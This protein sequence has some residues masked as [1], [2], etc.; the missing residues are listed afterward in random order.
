MKI[1]VPDLPYAKEALQPHISAQTVDIHYEKHH[2]GYL[3]KLKK[4]LEG[5]PALADN[6]LE[7]LIQR[8]PEATFNNAAQVWNHT[9]YWHS[10]TPGGGGNPSGTVQDEMLKSFQSYEDFKQLFSE[11]AKSQFGSGWAWLVFDETDRLTIRT[12]SDAE[13]P[14]R[15]GVSPLLALDVWEH[16]YYL[17]YRNERATYVEKFI[18]H[19]INWKF[20]EKNLETARQGVLV[21]VK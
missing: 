19:L 3:R 2:K 11:A 9:F 6:S 17:D 15:K 10:M 14:L 4:T 12:T 7:E 13:T 1:T 21:T 5:T 8:G 16:A 18:D 20:V